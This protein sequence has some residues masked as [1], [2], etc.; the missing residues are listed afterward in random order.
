M[1]DLPNIWENTSDEQKKHAKKLLAAT[2]IPASKG[3]GMIYE[4]VSKEQQKFINNYTV[5]CVFSML[6]NSKNTFYH[7]FQNSTELLP[8]TRELMVIEAIEVVGKRWQDYER[9]TIGSHQIPKRSR[10]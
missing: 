1:S 2:L 5:N 3:N 10:S 6:N 7:L 8:R 9:R 4:M